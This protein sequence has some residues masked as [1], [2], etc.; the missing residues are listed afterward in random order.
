MK[1]RFR[2]LACLLLL[3]VLPLTAGSVRVYITNSAGDNVHVIDPATNKVVEEIEVA[4]I[5][6]GIAIAPDGSRFYVS[7]EADR[8]LDVVDRK[9]AKSIRRVP[10]SG[11]PNNVAITRD[12]KRVYV[13]IRSE[14]WL[15]VVDTASLE[16]AKSIP[17][18]QG[19]HN[20]YLTPDGKY[21]VAGS[22]PGQSLTVIDVKTEEPVWELKFDVPVRPI[23]FETGPN[24]ETSRIFLQLSDLHG[25]AVVDF[26]AR[27]E[28]R[29]IELPEAPAE[30][31][32]HIGRTP[33][34]GIGVTPDGKTLWVNS[35]LNSAVYAYSLPDLKYLGGVAVG[36]V[37]DW[38]TFTPDSKLVYVSNAGSN[39]VSAVDVKSFKEVARIPVGQVPKRNITAVLP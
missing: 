22:I 14:S 30:A 11:H 25:F 33:S 7:G 23:T 18:G 16:K 5:P 36:M 2:H 27:K 39:S 35:S 26:A 31:Y 15:D 38:I 9:T 34:H 13:C 32:P 6:H 20:V 12:G 37:P 4:E 17:V 8:V 10:L 28:V 1:S 24:G 19:P 3:A 29:R 21:M